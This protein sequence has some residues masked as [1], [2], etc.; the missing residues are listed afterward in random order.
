MNQH[1]S[2]P[3][4]L[5]RVALLLHVVLAAIVI[6][7]SAAPLAAADADPNVYVVLWFDTEDYLLPA[8]DDAALHIATF[9]SGQDIRATFKVVGE[10]ARVLERRGRHDVIDALKKHEIGYH[11][12][13]HSVH[14]TI[15]AFLS[16]LGWDDGVAEFNRR[17][18]VGFDDLM[19]V[20]G[21]LPSCYGQP[22]SSWAP[23]AFGAMRQWNVPAYLDAG[24]HVELDGRP[25]W[26]CGV[27]NL[28]GLKYTLRTGLADPNDLDQAKQAF[29]DAYQHLLAEGGGMISIYYH[30]CEF[31]HRQFWDGVNFA[32]GANPPRE[33]W[34]QPPQ[35]SPEETKQAFANF[36]GYIRSIKQHPR[37]KFVTARDAMELYA[38]LAPALLSGRAAAFGGEERFEQVR[39]R[40]A[41]ELPGKVSEDISFVEEGSLDLSASETLVLINQAFLRRAAGDAPRPWEGALT[42]LGPTAAP[43]VL[44]SDLTVPMEQLVRTGRDVDDYIARLGRVPNAVWLGSHAVCPERYLYRLARLLREKELPDS[45]TFDAQTKVRLAAADYVSEDNPRLWG[46]VI[47]P[48]GFRAPEMMQLAKRQAWTLKPARL[49]RATKTSQAPVGRRTRAVALSN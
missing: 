17:E 6:V 40:I 24:S 18:R 23:Q 11:T 48:D 8:S 31:V 12:N 49:M 19:H 3:A 32:K 14:P 35:K 42:P 15:A 7:G 16:P 33:Q 37:I 20:F 45:V 38:D 34:K 44:E 47:F 36:E 41:A 25:F 4:A 13:F 27:L 22:G 46:W 30:P 9:L 5:P 2:R 43:P 10:K 21:Q 26:Y 1:P 28:Y 39:D 29:D